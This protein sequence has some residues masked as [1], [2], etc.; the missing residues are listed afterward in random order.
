MKTKHLLALLLIFL[1][2]KSLA[3]LLAKNQVVI[4]GTGSDQLKKLCVTKDGGILFAGQSGSDSSKY[5]SQV[6]RGKYD[7]WIVKTVHSQAN[8]AV[9]IQWEKTI[10]GDSIDNLVKAIPTEDGGYLLGGNSISAKSGEKSEDRVGG[11][12][13]WFVKTDA[14]GNIQW[15]KTIGNTNNTYPYDDNLYDFDQ[16][17]DGGYITTGTLGLVKLD[18]YGNMQWQKPVYY[19]SV[20]QLSDGSLIAATG[21]SIIKS[22]AAG[23]VIWE[24]AFS[25]PFLIGNFAVRQTSDHG[26]I[27]YQAGPTAYNENG[28]DNGFYY[29]FYIRII[30]TDSLGN[31][32][33]LYSPSNSFDLNP[34]SFCAIQETTDQGFIFGASY[35]YSKSDYYCLRLTTNGQLK[36]SKIIG[37]NATDILTDIV[38]LNTNRFMIGGYSNSPVS[39]QKTKSSL[40]NFDYWIL[41]L[42]DTTSGG[43]SSI[44]TVVNNLVTEKSKILTYPNPVKNILHIQHTGTASFML[45]SQAGSAMLV[46]TINGNG[47]INVS[48]L[49]AGIYYLK[50]NKNKEVQKVIIAR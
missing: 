44:S 38:E 4:G 45:T 37:G 13:Y 27:Y 3:Q 34:F 20:Q 1:V 42:T 14:N 9:K 32:Q 8:G 22:D 29:D 47:E 39:N 41:A 25:F 16:T 48:Q 24:K 17:L 15:D 49:P 50:N 35:G 31:Q 12:D 33:W 30:K 36:W 6:S 23:N 18:Q 10:C 46:K 26:F 21:S 5:K 43:L 7:Y 2:N 11:Y 40:G 28:G 19:R